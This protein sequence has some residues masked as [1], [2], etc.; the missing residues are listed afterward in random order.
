ML[1]SRII[2]L[3]DTSVATYQSIRDL[4]E[5]EKKYLVNEILQI[6]GLMPLLMKRRNKCAWTL[7]DETELRSHLTRLRQVS[8][9]IV[10]SILH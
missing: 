10:L 8:P 9:Y 6:K 5:R 3:R 1:Y 4:T 2:K 7:A